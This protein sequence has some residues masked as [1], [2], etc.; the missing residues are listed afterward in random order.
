MEYLKK[1]GNFVQISIKLTGK[2]TNIR[3]D[4]IPKKW[5]KELKPI[6]KFFEEWEKELQSNK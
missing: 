6:D 5:E 4:N 3:K 2:K 1:Y